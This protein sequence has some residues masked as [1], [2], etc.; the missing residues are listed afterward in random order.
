MACWLSLFEEVLSGAVVVVGS[1]I[2]TQHGDPER[3]L[4]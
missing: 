4:S 2:H 3:L 1:I